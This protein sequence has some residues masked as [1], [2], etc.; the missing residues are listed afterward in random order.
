MIVY[1]GNHRLF[2]E[3]CRTEFGCDPRTAVRRRLAVGVHD[4]SAR[5]VRGMS[6][7]ATLVVSPTA[8]AE[9]VAAAER[10]VAVVNL[11]QRVP[12]LS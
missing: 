9:L 2:T 11:H 3:Y 6:G 5:N 8:S 1:V 12:A 4:C 7:P 10:A